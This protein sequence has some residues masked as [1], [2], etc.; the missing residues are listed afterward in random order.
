MQTALFPEDAALAAPPRSNGSINRL[1]VDDR[2]FH[3]WYRFVLSFPA[4]LVREYLRRF[5]LNEDD[6][7][8]DPFCGAGTTLVEAKRHG[9]PST[10]IEANAVAHFA[11]SV[12]TDWDVDPAELKEH[13]HSLARQAKEIIDSWSRASL[14]TLPEES[15]NLLLNGSISPL[16]LHKSLVLRDQIEENEDA[17]YKRH[18]LLAL[19]NHWFFPPATCILARR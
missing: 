8:L 10:G 7:L 16:P 19:Q 13:A 15:F 9:I 12:K 11:C 3:D 2:H 1:D 6:M 14:R 4:H 5:E 17:G 18:E